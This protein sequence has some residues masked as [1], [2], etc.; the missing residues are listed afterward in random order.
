M[1]GERVLVVED[2]A[3]IGLELVES[4]AAQG[5]VAQ[6]ASTGAAALAAA[7]PMPDLVLVDLGLPDI[8][9]MALCRQL[10]SRLPMAVLVVLTARHDELDV[11]MALDSGADDYLTKPFRLAELSARLRAHLRR[12]PD[13]ADRIVVQAGALRLDLAG[14]RSFVGDHEM[15][16]RPKEFDLL[17]ALAGRTGEVVR[18][19][20]LMA[21][22]WDEHWHGS[23][24]TLD[25]H[26]A[27]LR[28]RLS[29]AGEGGGCIDTVRGVGYRYEAE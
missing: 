8:D 11:V 4:L 17:V 18:R 15:S 12:V 7:T 1:A 2:D 14:R 5:Y 13:S 21:E 20:D 29:E 3:D 16:L 23:T 6:L 9:G 25:V 27:A 22:V 24:K 28:R 10:R 19:E 26:V